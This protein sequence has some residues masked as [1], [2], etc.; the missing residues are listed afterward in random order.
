ML[1][2]SLNSSGEAVSALKE[3]S[4][5][6]RNLTYQESLI[7]PCQSCENSPC[8]TYLPLH[9]FQ[10]ENI[11]ELDHAIYLLNFERIELGLSSSGEW[12]VYYRYP[13]RFLNRTDFS[14]SIHN[15]PEQ[16]QICVSYNPYRCWYKRVLTKNVSD[17]FLR[18]DRLR[19]EYIVSLLTFDETG[20]IVEIPSWET[21]LDGVAK[22]TLSPNHQFSDLVDDNPVADTWEQ[23]VLNPEQSESATI[24]T[25]NDLQNPCDSCQAHCCKTLVFPQPMPRNISNLDYLKFCLGFSGIE[26][27]IADDAWSIVVKTTCRHL[28]DNRCS[29]YGM[30]TRPLL[31]KYYDAWKCTY[32][33]NFG[34]PRPPGFLRVKLDHFK[35]LI[36]CFKF[37]EFGNIVQALSTDAIRQYVEVEWQQAMTQCD[38]VHNAERQG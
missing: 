25:Y 37:D 14:C 26:V 31:C 10:I 8:C 3:N 6:N 1:N 38:P 19:M 15:T 30:N 18:I 17:E 27:G 32:K 22:L 12:S 2:T 4:F 9:T 24:L 20:T 36:E 21:L 23:S 29:I 7:S 16:P 5:K 13:C 28:Q 34:T 33:K 35:W 11:I